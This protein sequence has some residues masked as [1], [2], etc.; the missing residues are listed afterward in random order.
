MQNLTK[1]EV[2]ILT[3]AAPFAAIVYPFRWLKW[4]CTSKYRK[5][6][7]PGLFGVLLACALLTGCATSRQ[8]ALLERIAVALERQAQEPS[9]VA[10]SP[11]LVQPFYQVPQPFEFP[12]GQW[13]VTNNMLLLN[14]VTK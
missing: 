9:V 2:A 8:D 11:A 13:V 7:A 5:G 3:I 6:S 14:G 1:T 12:T 4:A 10:P